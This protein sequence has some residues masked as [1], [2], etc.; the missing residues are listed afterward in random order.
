VKNLLFIC[1]K[2]KLRSPT[3]EAV[4]S[5]WEGIE[6]DSAGINA[7]ADTVVSQEQIQW[8]DIIFVMEDSHRI[9]LTRKFSSELKDKHVVCLNIPD[10][11]QYMQ[12][13]LIRMLEVKV[14]KYLK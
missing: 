14:G 4:F 7:D 13:D 11:F 6:T 8:S 12:P 5:S 2:N 3:A 9:K 10:K 1:G